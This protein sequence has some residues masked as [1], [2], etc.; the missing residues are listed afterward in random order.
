[1]H[2]PV[3][4]TL[5]GWEEDIA[6]ERSWDKLPANAENYVSLIERLAGVPVRAVSTGPGREDIIW[7]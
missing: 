7:R 1:M 4:E 2:R 3:Y 5:P 6:G